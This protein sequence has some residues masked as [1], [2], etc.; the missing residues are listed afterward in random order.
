MILDE[1]HAEFAHGFALAALLRELAHFDF[2]DVAADRLR[3]ELRVRAVLRQRD[4]SVLRG[5]ATPRRQGHG[6]RQSGESSSRT[7]AHGNPP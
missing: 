5:R 4:L 3:Q 2:G 7:F 6:C 1:H